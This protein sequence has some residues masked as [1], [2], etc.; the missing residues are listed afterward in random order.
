[1]IRCSSLINFTSRYTYFIFSFQDTSSKL[2]LTAGNESCDMDSIACALAHAYMLSQTVPTGAFSLPLL[3]CT[4]TD[5]HLRQD[6]VWLFSELGIDP[7]TL[8]Y[9][10]DLSAEVLSSVDELFIT[11]VDHNSPKGFLEGFRPK[12]AEVIDH[13]EQ[14]ESTLVAGDRVKVAIENVG[15]CSTLVA[16]RI[17]GDNAGIVDEKLAALLLASIL[18][19]TGDLKLQGRT[20]DKDN[21]VAEQLLQKVASNIDREQ[22]YTKLFEQRSDISQLTNMDVLRRDFKLEQVGDKFSFGFCTVTS[23]LSDF[24]KRPNIFQDLLSFYTSQNL[25][26]LLLL[27]IH[28]SCRDDSEKRRQIAIFRPSSQPSISP[29]PHLLESLASLLEDD[30]DLNCDRVDENIE[31]FDGVLLE[32]GNVAVTRKQIIPKVTQFVSSV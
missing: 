5:L 32:Q 14:T 17:L 25:D 8:L 18:L 9:S 3:Q 29:V 26:A 19:D 11:L 21:A 15:S 1:M 22:F 7:D 2:Y 6:V 10:D 27:G 23:L 20:T 24:F 16:E 12:I 28:V 4:R 30:P 31:G 13:H